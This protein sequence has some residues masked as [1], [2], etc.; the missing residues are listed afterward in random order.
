MGGQAI[1]ALVHLGGAG[2]YI[3]WGVVQISLSNIIIIGAMIVLFLIAIV[4]PF[5]RHGAKGK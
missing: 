5:P 2:R 1:A 3:H 4:L